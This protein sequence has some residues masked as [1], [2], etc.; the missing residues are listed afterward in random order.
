MA[1]LIGQC[2]RPRWW[3]GRVYLDVMNRTHSGVTDWGLGRVSISPGATILDV[4]CG[5]GRTIQKLAEA[6]GGR[7]CGVDYSAASVAAARR[8]NAAAI[9]AGRVE[10]V[11]GSVSRLPYPDASFDVVTAVETHYYW[12]N[13][14]EDLREVRRVLEPGGQVVVIAEV[15]RRKKPAS[16]LF[17]PIMRLLGGRYVTAD[18]HRAALMQAGF[19]EVAVHEDRRG[20]ICATGRSPMSPSPA[21]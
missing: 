6:S 17:G 11:E 1:L 10:I 15:Y 8:T 4:G 5:G 16:A 19:V 2:R 9:A 14:G 12:P 20:W 21:A 18:E 13:L 3:I 7:V